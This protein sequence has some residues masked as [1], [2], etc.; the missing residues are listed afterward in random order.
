[1]G[2]GVEGQRG[3]QGGRGGQGGAPRRRA[4][5]LHPTTPTPVHRPLPPILP[6]A[7][8]LTRIVRD[9]GVR[10]LYRGLGPTLAAL[11]PNWAVYFTVYDRM[12][13][14]LGADAAHVAQ[15]APAPASGEAALRAA[16]IDTPWSAAFVS[17]V[18]R[19][20][21]ATADAFH[22]SN[23]HRAY[24]YDAFAT[25]AAEATNAA[26]K[27]IYRAC[28]VTTTRPRVGDLI[29]HQREPAL[30]TASDTE[31]RERI[32]TELAG[33]SDTRSVRRTHCDVI[34]HIDARAH[35]MYIIS[36]NVYH[37]VSAR[38]LNLRRNLTLS[39]RQHGNCSDAARWSL[40]QPATATAVPSSHTGS[41]SLN[42]R[43]WFV[44][45]QLR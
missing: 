1:M 37:A 14:L 7:V 42:D 26:S 44:L 24:I 10:G 34:A 12:K 45:L 27:Q 23:A 4:P 29:C 36:G 6:A 16:V 39:A 33:N 18:I 21:G 41:C 43:K 28:P 32:R 38:K 25:S 5:P 19:Q 35:K 9:E 2:A 3:S 31:V 8:N 20:A 17:Y 22:F 13:G 11:L 30:A 40:P 15:G